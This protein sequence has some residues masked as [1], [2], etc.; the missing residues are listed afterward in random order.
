MELHTFS[1]FVLHAKSLNHKIEPLEGGM[2]ISMPSSEVVMI[3]FVCRDCEIRIENLLMKVDLILFELDELDVILGM[4]FLTKYQAVLDCSNKEVI[5]RELGKF[6]VKFVGNKKVELAS[7]ISVLKA[8]K[9]M[10]KGHIAY[11][12]C[13]IDTHAIRNDPRSVSIVCAYLDLFPEE[14]SRLPYKREIEFTIEVVP[15]TTSIC[16]T[17]YRMAP[18]ELKELKD[19]LE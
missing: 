6:E 5:L 13:I 12:A 16:R 8:K 2:L 17:P 9:L 1:F 14:M 19:Q 4:D 3:E 7:I 18:S 11:L 10:K 15:R